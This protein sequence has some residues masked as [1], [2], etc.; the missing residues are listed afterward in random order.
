MAEEVALVARK[1]IEAKE[2]GTLDLS[3]C[4][5]TTL[6]DAIFFMLADGASIAKCDLSNNSLKNISSKIPKHFNQM[7]EFSCASNES[8]SKLPEEFCN[9]KK[10][11]DLNIS[12]N[13]FTTVPKVCPCLQK[14]NLSNNLITHFNQDDITQLTCLKEINLQGNN[15][16]QETKTKLKQY[17]NFLL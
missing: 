7:E 13:K 11:T 4:Q 8:I 12:G 3:G 2:T 16:D 14:V 17:S 9:L 6:P 15:L 1:C 10:L 5:L